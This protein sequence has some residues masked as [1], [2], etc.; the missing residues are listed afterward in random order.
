MGTTKQTTHSGDFHVTGKIIADRGIESDDLSQFKKEMAT[1]AAA[2]TVKSVQTDA[3]IA[4]AAEAAEEAAALAEL[5]VLTLSASSVS[6]NRARE[7]T[8]STLTIS[9]ATPRGVAYTG[10]FTIE[11]S[12]DTLNYTTVYTSPENENTYTYT[13]PAT[14]EIEG[15]TYYVASIRISLYKAGDTTTLY[16][17]E[18]VSVIKDT[19][20]AAMYL[21]RTFEAHPGEYVD[22]DSWLVYGDDDAT[23]LRGVYY[24][25]DGTP[26]SRPARARGLKHLGHHSSLAPSGSRPARARGL[27]HLIH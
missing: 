8:P 7:L 14:M 27:K 25:N 16:D 1:A 15:T 12:Q 6:R 18:Y 19:S 10:I 17:Q 13:I 24:S 20:V 11:L 5:P 2:S 21:G 3:A 4:A 26:T 23:V 9:A 22:G